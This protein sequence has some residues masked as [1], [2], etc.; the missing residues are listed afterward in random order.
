MNAPNY[1]AVLFTNISSDQSETTIAVL[2]SIGFEGFEEE[3]DSLKAYISA[4]VFEEETF[5]SVIA[6]LHLSYEMQTIPSQNW[7][8]VWEGQFEPVVVADFVG[9][10]AHFHP[11]FEGR[12]KHEIVITPKMSFGT[13]HHATTW[14]M[15]NEMQR[16]DFAEKRVFDFGTGTGILAILSEK[17]GASDI[18]AID[19]DSW[20]IENAQEN[21]ASNG[22]KHI[23]LVQTG[24]VPEGLVF[25]LVLANINKNVILENMKPLTDVLTENGCLLLSGLL[26]EDEADILAAARAVGLTHRYTSNK[27]QWIAMRFGS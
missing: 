22:C 4:E 2:S 16:L 14:M 24:K 18:L 15:M 12:V 25:D 1:I 21:M 10:R 13:G 5:T 27:Q 20:S 3:T 6:P 11:S 26:V 8:A 17:L 9:I 7:N 23:R 19:N